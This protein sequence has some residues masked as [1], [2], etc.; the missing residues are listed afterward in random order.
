[1]SN[2]RKWTTDFNAKRDA[3]EAFVK[4]K[5]GRSLNKRRDAVKRA[6]TM[7]NSLPPYPRTSLIQ[8]GAK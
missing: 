7:P 6:A 3:L 1:M 4:A 8:G 2:S 5:A